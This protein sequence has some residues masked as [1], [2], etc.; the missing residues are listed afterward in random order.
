M[1]IKFTLDALCVC[2]FLPP[3]KTVKN[4]SRVKKSSSCVIFYCGKS[5]ELLK[6]N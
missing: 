4:V 2:P 6:K 3:S 1:L 5:C